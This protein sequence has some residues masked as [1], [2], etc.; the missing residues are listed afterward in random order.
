MNRPT[1]LPTPIEGMDTCPEL[2]SLAQYAEGILGARRR[3]DV[4][5]HVAGCDRC[6]SLLA[7]LAR[8]AL[9]AVGAVAATPT[10]RL[11]SFTRG[12]P[13]AAA[14]AVLVAG[15][16]LAL[17]SGAPTVADTDARLVAVATRLSTDRPDLF[18]GFRSLDARER[19][20]GGTDVQRGGIDS[21]SPSGVTVETR[22]T[23]EWAEVDGASDYTVSVIDSEGN[24]LL[25][26]TA[27]SARLDGASLQKALTRGTDYVWK[28]T[29][30]G[31][32]TPAEGTCALRVS[33][34][35]E[36]NTYA[37]IVVAVAAATTTDEG[38]RDLATAHALLRRGF[39]ADALPF[40]R[41]HAAAN[42][43]DAVGRDTLALIR[44]RL[45]ANRK[46]N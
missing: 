20:A 36:A 40:A 46:P 33:S 2:D 5:A 34:E 43:S 8:A 42:L 6:R 7:D 29:A 35:A 31:S 1:S 25:K 30:V 19:S 15:L 16:V 12:L 10:G 14:A 9:V 44:R 22:P 37:A 24:R 21:M 23:F 38:L 26:Q 4:D 45:S 3:A 18:A 11:A 13:I 39:D 32:V 27:N 28:V 41:R 17:R